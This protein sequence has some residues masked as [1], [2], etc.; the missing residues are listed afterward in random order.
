ML[1]YI[2]AAGVGTIGII[3]D[4][5]VAQSN[6]QRQILYTI[7]DIGFSKAETAAKRLS[8]LN[9]FVS[10]NIYKKKLTRENAISLFKKYD[11]I[12]SNLL[13]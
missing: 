11:I 5:V 9:P 2:T 8:K 1:Q 3:D 6:L 7:D 4:D 13:V 10:F 12:R